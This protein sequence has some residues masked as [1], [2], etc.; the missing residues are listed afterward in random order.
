MSGKS[1]PDGMVCADALGLL[2]AWPLRA[3]NE[4]SGWRRTG[5]GKGPCGPCSRVWIFTLS[6]LG[7]MGGLGAEEG[8]ELIEHLK[9]LTLATI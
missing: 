9:R 4:A 7:T 2:C 6:E 5:K 8:Q 3:S 1:I